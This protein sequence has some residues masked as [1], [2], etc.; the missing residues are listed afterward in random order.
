MAGSAILLKASRLDP[1][2]RLGFHR[3][4]GRA[5]LGRKFG[6]SRIF[7]MAVPMGRVIKLNRRAAHLR[8]ILR[9]SRMSF[10]KTVEFDLMAGIALS[11]GHLLD[12]KVHAA[13][14]DVTH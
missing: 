9:E 12:I 7:K 1:A 11:I 13:V 6:H 5:R 10:G 3:M 4:T 8:E 14:F 2:L